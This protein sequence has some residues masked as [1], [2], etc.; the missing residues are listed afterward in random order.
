MELLDIKEPISAD[1]LKGAIV[2]H[3]ELLGAERATWTFGNHD[4]ARMTSRLQP[5]LVGKD[6]HLGD[7][8]A[9]MILALELTLPG[10]AC[11]Y[12]GDE[13]GL[14]QPLLSI[15]EM[16]DPYDRMFYPDHLGRDGARAPIAWSHDAI[17]G[18]FSSSESTWLPVPDSHR[19]L[20]VDVQEKNPDSVL[21]VYRR[22]A[23]M[24]NNEPSLQGFEIRMLE[25]PDPIVAYERTSQRASLTAFF[26]VSHRPTCIDIA[27]S[28][29]PPIK[30]SH[31]ATLEAKSLELG[32]Y[33]FIVV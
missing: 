14:R 8:L 19:S 1:R 24:R 10:G 26:N 13:L 22:L 18:G 6:A 32:P 7:G 9:K 27:E 33:G 15:D 31:R 3:L 2:S 11:V 21:S 28:V 30:V 5:R 12:Q 17:S 16:R 20:A 29:H 23:S 4:S 25:T